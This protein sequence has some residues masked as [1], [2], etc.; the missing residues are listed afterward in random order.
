MKAV[1]T[2]CP[3]RALQV[4]SERRLASTIRSK[5][6]C[7]ARRK[8]RQ[9]RRLGGGASATQI[10]AENTGCLEGE[11]GSLDLSAMRWL[12]RGI[13]IARRRSTSDARR[14]AG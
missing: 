6:R 5:A 13:R 12:S 14:D 9:F 7:E 4:L 10:S 3:Q 2:R 8:V 1:Q 11:L